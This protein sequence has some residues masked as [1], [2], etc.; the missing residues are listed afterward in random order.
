[1]DAR[2]VNLLGALTVALGDRLDTAVST[3]AGHAGAAASV[4]A[5]LHAEPGLGVQALS[6][7]V[8]ISPSG[9]VRLLDRLAGHALVRREPGR[10]G[11]SVALHLTEAGRGAARETLAQ[12]EAALAVAL[13]G[14]T[15]DERSTL[16][17][18][19]ETMLR[20]LTDDGVVAAR[21]CRLC[22]VDAC[23]QAECPVEQAI[24]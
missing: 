15:A 17:S 23:P 12:R 16:S 8:G 14:L 3:V 10:D 9:T 24:P 18:L 4:L 1:M 2:L 19:L 13:E 20:D 22:D 21:I 11:R 7:V 5:A 6:E